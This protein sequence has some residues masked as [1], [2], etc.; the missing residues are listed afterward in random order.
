MNNIFKKIHNLLFPKYEWNFY[1]PIG[2]NDKEFVETK[3]MTGKQAVEHSMSYK[4]L[5]EIKS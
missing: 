3:L 1:K 5:Y 2:F 4:L